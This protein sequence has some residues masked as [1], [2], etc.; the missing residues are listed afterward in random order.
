VRVDVAR[1]LGGGRDGLARLVDRLLH[2]EATPETR[3]ALAAHAAAAGGDGAGPSD[4][5]LGTLVGLALG[6]PDFQRR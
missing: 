4:V 3:R 5:E 1:A 2:G 6:S